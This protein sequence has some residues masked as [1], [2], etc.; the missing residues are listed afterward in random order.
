MEHLIALLEAPE[1]GHGVLHRGLPHQH[2]LEAALQRGVLFDILAVLVE[3]GGADA[4]ELAPGQH[5]LEEVACIHGA[6]GLARAHDGVELVDEEDDPSLGLPDLAQHRFEPLF[7]LAAVLGAGHQGTHIQGEDGLV[8]QGTGHVPFDDPLGQALGDGGLAHAGL[9]DEDRIVLALP[10]QDADHVSDLVVPTDDGVQ[11]I[12]PGPLHQIG[13]VFLEGVV[14]LLR[15]VGGHPLVAPD[16]GEGFEHPLLG[17]VVGTEQVFEPAVGRLHQ[18]E[19]QMLHRD[20]FILHGGGHGF[21]PVEGLVHVGGDIDLARLPAAAHRHPRQLLYLFTDGRF[22][23]RDGEAHA[24]QELRDQA[25]L[26]LQQCVE[27]MDL[28]DLLVAVLLGDGLG[29]L[30]RFQG[31]LCELIHVHGGSHPFR[32]D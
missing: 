23:T 1:D 18:G 26:L 29:V 8:L 13:T 21:R 9:A 5:G 20:I 10:A 32:S 19:E 3:G 22:Q 27:E 2:G 4:V 15:V 25:V 14:G 16:G 6:L 17:D 12:L 24:A 31:F 11:L 7:K 30:H 28:F